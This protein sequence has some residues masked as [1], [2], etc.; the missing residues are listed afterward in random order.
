[1]AND[2]S[3]A[4]P[5][6]TQPCQQPQTPAGGEI[7]SGDHPLEEA[8]RRGFGPLS[9]ASIENWHGD[10]HPCVTCGQLVRR[11]APTCDDCGQDL[12]PAMIE[13][14]RA[15]AGPWYVL[16]HVRP[17]PGV[18]VER[19][20]RQ[21]NRGLITETSIVR[22]PTTDYQWRFAVET[23]GLCRLFNRCWRCHGEA[24]L[25][26]A[27]CRTCGA[28]V[29]FEHPVSTDVARRAA[30][31]SR[32]TPQRAGRA[33]PAT[34]S[35]PQGGSIGADGRAGQLALLSAAA[36]SVQRPQAFDGAGD[37]M[38]MGGVRL[39]WI[40]VIIVIG[41]FSALVLTTR[42]R[43]NNVKP[44]TKNAATMPV[45]IPSPTAEPPTAP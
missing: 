45:V 33:T 25:A 23:P 40:A 6:A 10:A 35:G 3:D 21:V 5:A 18:S 42:A 41:V 36:R 44:P 32:R 15:H 37:A 14:M 24:A 7:P 9:P 27:Q 20:I 4:N 11:N 30:D 29:S 38:R 13:R 31:N 39:A 22:G 16:E 1:M 2:M 19:V 26:E 12:S 28:S 8:A 17:F 34:L 43:V